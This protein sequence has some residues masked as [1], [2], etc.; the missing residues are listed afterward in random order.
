MDNNVTTLLMEEYK[1]VSKFTVHNVFRIRKEDLQC[2]FIEEYTKLP[3][4]KVDLRENLKMLK[5]VGFINGLMKALNSDVQAG[6]V[7]DEQ[8]IK[9]R[10]KWFGHNK[11]PLP[12]PT[13]L[14][15]SFKEQIDDAVI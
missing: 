4:D 9:R 8:D 12:K 2:F 14:W 5:K 11:K 15:T 13:S 3:E 10:Q 1:R 7:G 6:I